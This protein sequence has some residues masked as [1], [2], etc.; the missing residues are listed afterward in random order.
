MSTEIILIGPTKAGKSTL[1]ALL[2]QRLG[3]P[4]CSL[5]AARWQYMREIGHD[6][7]L[8]DQF[9]ERGG[10]LARVLYWQLFGPYVVERFLAEHSGCVMDFGAGHTVYD[11]TEM[12][13]RVERAMAPY[14]NVFLILPSPDPETSIHVLNER[15]AVEG[16]WYNFDFSAHFVRHASNYKLAK[17]IVY[18]EQRT[19]EQCADGILSYAKR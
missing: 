15:L 7:Q 10:A 5:D 18:T 17:H 12:L 6:K 2:A 4:A 1:A 3:I 19:P 13:E 11:S 16:V 9:R 14:P 8:D